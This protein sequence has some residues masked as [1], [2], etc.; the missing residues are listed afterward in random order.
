M[1]VMARYEVGDGRFYFKKNGVRNTIKITKLEPG[2][3]D[4]EYN[5]YYEGGVR[6]FVDTNQGV[7]GTNTRSGQF[8]ISIPKEQ[9]K[10]VVR[11]FS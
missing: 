11:E 3:Y 7:I 6:G 1:I 10:K 4:G 9:A 8:K 5:I 2:P